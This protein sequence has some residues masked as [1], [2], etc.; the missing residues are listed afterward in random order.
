M[1]N[2]GWVPED[3]DLY[4]FDVDGVLIRVH[5]PFS[6]RYEKEIGSPGLMTTF[7]KGVFQE[8]LVGKADLKEEAAKRLRDWKWDGDVD[9]FLEHWFSAEAAINYEVV[10]ILKD[11]KNRN[12]PCYLITNQEKYR[13]EYLTEK[14]DIDALADGLYSSSM[15]GVKKPNPEFYMA[16]LK[17]IGFEGDLGRVFYADNEM[18]NVDAAKAVGIDAFYYSA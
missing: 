13:T 17:A 4:L 11:L 16:T 18:P 12:K 2:P 10:D 1:S 7:F 8:C 5:E 6:A 3:R 9:T 15:L 14:L